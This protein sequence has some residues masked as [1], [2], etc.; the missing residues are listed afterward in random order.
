MPKK[1]QS[2]P[3]IT[4]KETPEQLKTKEY[5]TKLEAAKVITGAP[6]TKN[7]L[8]AINLNTEILVEVSTKL[9]RLLAH[10]G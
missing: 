7:I 5:K 8:D 9:N 6:T 3:T 10:K 1:P 2:I 4:I